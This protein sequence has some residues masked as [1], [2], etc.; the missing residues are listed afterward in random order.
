MKNTGQRI[1][2]ALL[3]AAAGLGP[4]ASPAADVLVWNLQ[5]DRVDADIGRAD[6]Q[7]VLGRISAA[8]GWDI[9]IEPKTSL[10]V[11]AKFKNLPR[12]EALKLLLGKLNYA[13]WRQTNGVSRLAVYRTTPV[14]AT[15]LIRSPENAA[16][17]KGAIPNELIVTL[18]P[19]IKIDDLARLLGARVV[20]RAEGLNSYRLQF[21]DESAARLAQTQLAA[22]PSVASV[23]AN[24]YME[25]PPSAE[26][27]GLSGPLPFNLKPNAVGDAN[28][29]IVG[30]ID[31][32]LQKMGGA[33]DQ[34]LLPSISVAGETVP[35]NNSPT[36]GTSMGETIL[37]G[38]ANMSDEADA[39]GSRVRI[40]PV[41]VYGASQKTT[42]FD[43]AQGIYTAVNNGA[44][45]INLSLGSPGD[46]Q[47]LHSVIE[48][49]H[50]QGVLLFAAAGNEPTTAPTYP[51][52][53][54]EVIAV[55]AGDRKG[56][57]AGYA[58]RGSFVDIV[59][60]GSTIVSFNNKLYF[61]SGTS[62]STAYAAGLAAGLAD[63]SG[64]PLGQ[65]ESALR[66]TF[67]VSTS[68]PR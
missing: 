1:L 50:D 5:R 8:T 32:P 59:T 46:S 63:S 66:K 65:V 44:M 31:S 11:S 52:A 12:D 45:I 62:A 29:L 56:N 23:D 49:A 7:A 4:I 42:T 13:F 20:G 35:A 64:K 40:L 25:P 48:S 17:K 16:A 39:E 60:P 14:Q 2:L 68:T 6:L 36:H 58:N 22:D 27:T 15:V 18:K 28:H 30:L 51:A 26:A 37:R 33:M 43:V 47:I 57:I 54:P 41:D 55:T 19:G 67:A 3:L 38:L 21:S 10:S 34:F 61:V 53:Y 24:F 9:Y